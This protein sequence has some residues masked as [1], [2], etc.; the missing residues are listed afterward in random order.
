MSEAPFK[1]F[2]RAATVGLAAMF[3]LQNVAHTTPQIMESRVYR[4][5][6]NLTPFK[7]V[8]VSET[9]IE[10]GDLYL[11]GSMVKVR[12]VFDE[13]GKGLTAYAIYEDQDNTRVLIETSLE[14]AQGVKG[15]RPPNPESQTWGAWRLVLPQFRPTPD[16]YQIIAGHWCPQYSADGKVIL[17]PATMEPVLK[18]E[19]NVFA[20]GPWIT[21]D[22]LLEM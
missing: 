17:D 21:S 1:K 8:I 13:E 5:F 18:F 20:E 3:V 15:N 2:R 16:G 6:V 11:A 22:Q 7:N 10:N 14:D 19:Y 9:K 12:C 4:D